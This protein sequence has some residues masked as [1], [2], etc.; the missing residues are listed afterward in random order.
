MA[1]I[2]G[3][4]VD[5][6]PA[7]DKMIARLAKMREANKK[8]LVDIQSQIDAFDA[9]PDEL[10]EEDAS[11]FMMPDQ[12]ADDMTVVSGDGIKR[13]KNVPEDT[14]S[15]FQ[16][17]YS[18]QPQN[19]YNS[20]QN[21]YTTQ[22]FQCQVPLGNN[23]NIGAGT[24]TCNYDGFSKFQSNIGNNCFIGSNT[25]MISPINIE[26]G[27]MTGA[28]SIITKN[29]NKDDIAIARAKQENLSGKAINYRNKRKK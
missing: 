19:A 21:E 3:H 10:L 6:N 8:A 29:V 9:T 16:Q 27:A 2:M 20:R 15:V 24:I 25:V 23:T 28:G 5:L 17:P 4:E 26:D 11:L 12:D 13:G 14:P 7:F 1:I 22:G 18:E